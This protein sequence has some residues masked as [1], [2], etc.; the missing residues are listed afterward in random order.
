M[1]KIQFSFKLNIPGFYHFKQ[2]FIQ[3]K[4]ILGIIYYQTLEDWNTLTANMNIMKM[5]FL[6]LMIKSL[7]FWINT[8]YYIKDAKILLFR[9]EHYTGK[10]MIL[11]TK[12]Y[13][14]ETL[15]DV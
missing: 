6:S 14:T 2:N 12:F 1:I 10:W 3:S 8:L 11:V 5:M 7:C 9:M 13:P 15:I 4:Q